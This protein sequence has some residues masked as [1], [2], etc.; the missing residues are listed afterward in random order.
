MWD[1]CGTVACLERMSAVWGNHPAL[2]SIT[3]IN[4]PSELS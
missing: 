3:V 2:D 4:E 1:A